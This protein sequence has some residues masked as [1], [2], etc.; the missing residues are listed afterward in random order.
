MPKSLSLLAQCSLAYGAVAGCCAW[1]G[2]PLPARRRV[3][4]SDRCAG[5]F[6]SNH[7]WSLARRA[8]KRRDRYRCKRCGERA[9]KRPSGTAFGTKASYNAAMRAWRRLRKTQR[10]EV[11]HIAQARGRHRELSCIHHLENLETLCA[12]CHKIETKSARVPPRGMP[13]GLLLSS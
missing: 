11:N 13:A 1:C 6:W 3:W 8:A 12:G 7:W 2:A 9:P 5:A 4:C 10:L